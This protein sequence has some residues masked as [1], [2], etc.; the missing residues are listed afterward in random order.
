MDIAIIGALIA[1]SIICYNFW[2]EKKEKN[3]INK[4]NSSIYLVNYFLLCSSTCNNV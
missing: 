3:L 2:G 4:N 1:I